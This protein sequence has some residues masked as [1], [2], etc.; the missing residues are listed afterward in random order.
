MPTLGGLLEKA[1]AR[2]RVFDLGRRVAKIPQSRFRQIER[3]ERPYPLPLQQQAWLGVL[4]W[5]RIDPGQHFVWFLR[6]PLDET[7]Q[8]QA[9]ARDEF[10]EDVLSALGRTA[11]SAAGIRELEQESPYAFKPREERLAAF[12]AKA[13]VALK[14]GPSRFYAHGRDYLAGAPGYD[15]W[16]FVGLQGLADVAARLDQDG[17]AAR[18]AE[19]I[20][21]LPAEPLCL[22]CQ[23]LENE[24][25]P[26]RVAASLHR[27]LVAALASDPVPVAEVTALVR[28][29]GN[30]AHGEVRHRMLEAVL[31][32]HGRVGID[33]LVAL[34]GR[35]W[36]ALR[37]DALRL[38]YLEV[39]AATEAGRE[40][41]PALM[42]DLL[43]VPGMRPLLLASFR[44]PA[45]TPELVAAIG[46]LLGEAGGDA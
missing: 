3:G 11:G 6:F 9:A 18:V 35:A 31:E 21:Q 23:L 33:P 12:H 32:S 25:L 41:F 45:R 10:L 20:P 27:R 28:A 7:G 1:N 15:Q 30:T 19:A 16:A 37:D 14:R 36:E 22:L 43:F 38:R 46:G 42:R 24:N 26:G 2:Y 40:L 13:L 34:G 39:L 5:D 29:I 4:F 17:N 8:L 44:N